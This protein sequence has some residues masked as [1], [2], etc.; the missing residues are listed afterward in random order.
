MFKQIKLELVSR[1]ICAYL[2]ARG[3]TLFV[4]ITDQGRVRGIRI[5][6]EVKNCY[7]FILGNRRLLTGIGSYFEK[8]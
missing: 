2:N 4:G 6:R 5:T 1:Y 8:V 3:G 7:V